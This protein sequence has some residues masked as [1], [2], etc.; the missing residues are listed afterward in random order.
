MIYFEALHIKMHV[1]TSN[2]NIAS[3]VPL[4][5]VKFYTHTHT[6]MDGTT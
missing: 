1:H 6:H 5:K 4:R 3:L 2:L